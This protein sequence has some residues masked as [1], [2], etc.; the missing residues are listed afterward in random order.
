M[1]PEYV[2]TILDFS[3]GEVHIHEYEEG[4]TTNADEI[5]REFGYKESD[6]QY[7]CTDKLKLQIH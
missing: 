3:T 2:I 4:I 6:C 7:L 5:V 1:F